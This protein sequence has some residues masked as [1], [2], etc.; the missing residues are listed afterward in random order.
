MERS[1]VAIHVTLAVQAKEV[2]DVTELYCPASLVRLPT[3]IQQQA[4]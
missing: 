4:P 1:V 2:K 3:G